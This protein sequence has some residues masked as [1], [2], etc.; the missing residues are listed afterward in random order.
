M[1]PFVLYGHTRPLT[2][3]Q[4]SREGDLLFT[5]AKDHSPQVWYT[6]TGNRL[7]LYQGHTGAVS[8]LDIDYHT[9]LMLTGSAD[10]STRIWD[11][12]TGKCLHAWGEL[13]PVR[14]VNFATGNRHFLMA[15]EKLMGFEGTVKVYGI[16]EDPWN[17]SFSSEP[18]QSYKNPVEDHA[19]KVTM[20]RFTSLNKTFIT[21]GADG[22]LRQY[23]SETGQ[24]INE[25]DAHSQGIKSWQFNDSKTLLIT[26]S[27]DQTSKLFDVKTL[28]PLKT[29][30][31]DRPVNAACISPTR[32]H[33]IVGGGQEAMNVTTT[34]GKVGKFQA[35]I[36][37]TIFEDEIG[38]VKGHFGPLNALAFAPDGAGYSSGGEDGTVRIHKLDRS[39]FELES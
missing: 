33:V 17:D 36:F 32:A 28:E 23:D 11:V 39:Y 37:H 25:C 15:S 27:S 20:A 13:T 18:L 3:V 4:Y 1:R 7:G 12:Q 30:V 16:P 29:Y 31:T 6:E 10:N 8:H 2:W 5:C 35:R 22:Y 24:L 34:Q 38:L 21:S 19:G 26:A 14:T 9:R